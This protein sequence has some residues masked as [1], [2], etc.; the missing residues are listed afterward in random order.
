MTIDLVLE[1]IASMGFPIAMCIA[2][3]W[4]VYQVYKKSETREDALRDEI[5]E[6]Q[7]IN[8]ES[9]KTLALYA[10]RLNVIQADV[11]EIKHDIIVITD[12]VSN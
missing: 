4:F 3:I 9:I 7:E 11:E 5:R 12:K 1:L 8:K 10:E 6:N 2:L